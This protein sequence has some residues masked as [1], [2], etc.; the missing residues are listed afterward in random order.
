MAAAPKLDAWVALGA[1]AGFD[2]SAG[3][4]HRLAEELSGR[5]LPAT[6]AIAALLGAKQGSLS[7]SELENVSGGGSWSKVDGLGVSWDVVELN[8]TLSR[9]RSG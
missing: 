7:E 3:E 4:L 1:R 2:F 6:E 9:Y 5:T 8:A